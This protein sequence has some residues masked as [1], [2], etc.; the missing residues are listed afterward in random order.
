MKSTLFTLIFTA[1]ALTISIQNGLAQT[2]D[3]AAIK[4][5]VE[6]ETQS[7]I[8]RDAKAMADCWANVPEATHLYSLP[9]GKGTVVYNPDIEKAIAT[10]ASGQQ[11]TSDTFQNTDYQIRVSGNAAFTQFDQSYSS[12]D[13][14]K[15][16]SHQVR[17]LEKFSGA[18]KIVNVVSVYY[19]PT[20]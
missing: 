20:K 11:P 4:A 7:W 17:Y 13:G 9:D 8:K 3:K 18:W 16:Y 6:R 5:V 14:T 15:N 1:I 19:N 2:D 12:A 10:F